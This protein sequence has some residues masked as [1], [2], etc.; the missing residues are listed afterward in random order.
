MQ[1][2]ILA[3][4]QGQRLRDPEG[5]PKCLRTVGGRPL[6]DHQ[7]SALAEIGIEDVVIV[8]GYEQDMVRD[9]VG[10]GAR[11]VVNNRYAETNSM[12]SFLVAQ[13]MLDQ[14]V[15]V[16]NSDLFFHPGLAATLCETPGDALLYDSD[17]G[18]EDEH[19]KVRVRH[20]RLVEMSKRMRPER[21]A[22]ENVGM[23]KLSPRTMDQTA[24]AAR[25]ILAQGGERE[26][27]ASAVNRVAAHR[28]IGCVDVSGWPWVEIDFREDLD[29]A[30][31]DVFPAV[32]EDL[33]MRDDEWSQSFAML[34]SRP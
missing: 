34:G 21:V 18:G 3:A 4:G 10:A 17:S 32:A 7:I 29:R 33:S 11:Y 22:G 19:M 31:D 24:T 1:A 6:I 25:K 30:R 23:L 5:R 16:M 12:Y 27:L 13:S 14:E 26:W 2:L 8:V 15:V 20:G 28:A 9:A